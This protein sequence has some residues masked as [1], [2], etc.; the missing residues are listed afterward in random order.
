MAQKLI[1]AT[2]HCYLDWSNG[3]SITAREILC[4]LAHFGWDVHVLTGCKLDSP[5]S[6]DQIIADRLLT[7]V[8]QL[9]PASN[10]SFTLRVFND[11]GIRSI[12]FC[13]TIASKNPLPDEQK[14]FLRILQSTI[15]NIRPNILLT[16]D[17]DTLGYEILRMAKNAR[18]KTVTLLQNLAYTH[19]EYFKDVDAVLV[20]SEFTKKYYAKT[21]RLKPVAIPPLM[22]K[23]TPNF[24][25]NGKQRQFVT[26]VNP[27]P[28]KGMAWFAKI[29]KVLSDKSPDIKFLV[30][31]ARGK[32]D[33][34]GLTGTLLLDVHNLYK[35]SITPYPSEFLQVSK[36]MLIPSY[37]EE[38]FGR[39]AVEAM[40]N[41]IP[42]ISSNRGALPEAVGDAGILLPIPGRFQP[43]SVEVPSDEEVAQWVDAITNLWYD[44][45]AYRLMSQKGRE[46][47]AK[48]GWE[49]VAQQYT[50]FFSSLLNNRT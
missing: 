38:T 22:A 40:M 35:M 25:K 4:A 47:S 43:T 29:A 3:A 15:A 14:H 32:I 46:Y 19:K 11:H 7:D 37:Y 33:S 16:Y 44:N 31:E 6:I 1:F 48:W 45:T 5:D 36:L 28:G 9:K 21:L 10:S 2:R 34:L 50:S 24:C 27:A 26:F 17:G 42:V 49:V 20:P 39:V 13:P 30:V 8:R 12:L 41:G 23:E 18:M